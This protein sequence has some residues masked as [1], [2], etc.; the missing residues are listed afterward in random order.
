MRDR[1]IRWE[2]TTEAMCTIVRPT[3]CLDAVTFRDF[4]DRLV[5]YGADEPR[6]VV[7]VAD[8]LKLAGDPLLT[9]FTIAAD[10]I[11]EWP[12]IPLLIVAESPALHT[13]LTGTALKSFVRVF[14]SVPEA[15]A[16]VTD[17]PPRRRAAID[18][19]ADADS[20][21]RA[22]RFIECTCERWH[23]GQVRA[24]AQ[25]V[26]TELVENAFLHARVTGD[27]GLRLELRGERLV[28]AVH[29]PDPTPA[30]LCEPDPNGHRRYGLHVIGRLALRWGCTPEWL[31]G[32]TVW[33][34]LSVD[35]PA[36]N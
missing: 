36:L 5:K 28:I 19:M 29:D 15:L 4:V 13:R 9:A 12:G 6:A 21:R 32:K 20:A 14:A 18:L 10:Q 27:I 7:V 16:A 33:A 35:Q 23:I 31:G 34:T 25:L 30:V 24:G 2:T 26:G 22:R 3:G 1:S 17:P 11:D 8:G